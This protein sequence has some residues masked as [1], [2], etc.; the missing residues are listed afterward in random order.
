MPQ[1]AGFQ[2]TMSNGIDNAW[3]NGARVVL[4][5]APTGSGKTV[6]AGHKAMQHRG[7][8]C[9]MAHRRELVGQI[10]VAYARNGLV[11][12]IIG[13]PKT[14]KQVR[15]AHMEEFGRQYID[16]RSEWKVA[17]VDTL[18]N[19][20]PRDPW[21]QRVGL[22]QVDEG[23]HVTKLNKWGAAVYMFPNK[24][25]VL[26]WSATPDRADG[27]GLGAL[28]GGGIVDAM[29]EG[30]QARDLINQGYLT[31]YEVRC[32]DPSDLNLSGVSIGKDG[33]FISDQMRKAVRGSNAIVGDVVKT[34]LQ[35]AR[36]KLGVTF[37]ASI[38]DCHR[39][40][41]AFKAAGVPAAVVHAGTPEEER[42]QILRDFKNRKL[43]Q[44]I[45]VD[46]FGEGFDLPAIECV[47]MARPTWSFALYAQQW[48]RALRLMVSPILRAAWDTFSIEQRLQFIR[49]SGKPFA[50][51]FDH[52]GNVLRHR[53][54]PDKYRAWSLD[55][56][57]RGTSVSDGLIPQRVCLECSMPYERSA[58]ECPYCGAEPAPPGMGAKS[59][60]HTV[61]GDLILYSDELLKQLRGECERIAAPA[62]VP[63]ALRGTPAEV[64]LFR[65]HTERQAAIRELTDTINLWAGAN[66]EHS[67]RVNQRRFYHIFGVDILT[68]MTLSSSDA[69]QLKTKVETAINE[70]IRNT[71]T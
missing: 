14:I 26:L 16:P 38:E 34:Y 11:H 49:E 57:P 63:I 59:S 41:E 5:V 52:V 8:G 65:R 12:D 44:L 9:I 51:I 15:M 7:A 2:E 25:R 66:N 60:P 68:A 37:A 20:D 1:L 55:S 45:N 27:I 4:A 32:V 21:F 54:P 3:N 10:S 70:K 29:V 36:G 23:H 47:S 42:R 6:M 33:D 39:F 62:Y 64:A 19:M 17:S 67:D 22:V 46:L 69:I 58:L 71:G 35:H 53:G 43:L 18:I 40:C 56:R 50:Y 24:P 31:D 28:T 48:G 13:Q 30:P 61:D